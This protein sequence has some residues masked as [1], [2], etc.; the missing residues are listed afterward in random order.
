MVTLL[1]LS[2]VNNEKNTLGSP[3]ILMTLRMRRCNLERIA[4]Y[5]T[6]RASRGAT[7]RLHRAIIRTVLP[8]C[9]PWSSTA[10]TQQTQ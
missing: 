3:A 9:P 6:T 7:E 4:R 1:L 5:S 2:L 8:R 10:A